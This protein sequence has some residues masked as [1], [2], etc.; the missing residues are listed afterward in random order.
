ML[1]SVS[2]KKDE[3]QCFKT[4]VGPFVYG[5]SGGERRELVALK[6]NLTGEAHQ[7]VV[8]QGQAYNCYIQVR[9]Y[10][11]HPGWV[12]VGKVWGS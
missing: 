6:I 12:N 10:G 1:P 7:R 8:V 9:P 11:N 2:L 3:I 4:R 5:I